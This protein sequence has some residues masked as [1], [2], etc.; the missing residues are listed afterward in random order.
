MQFVPGTVIDTLTTSQ[1]ID[2]ISFQFGSRKF[3]FGDEFILNSE[4]P[5]PESDISE[6]VNIGVAILGW[7]RAD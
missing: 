6:S 5:L 4:K 3:E 1:G 2:E 7:I